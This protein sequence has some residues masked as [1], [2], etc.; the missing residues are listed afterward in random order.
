MKR[1]T[2]A[3][4]L[5][6]GAA[7][8]LTACGD[9]SPSEGA[10][11]EILEDATGEDADIDLSDGEIRVQT[12]EGEVKIDIDEDDG[13]FEMSV[14]GSQV[15]D[16]EFDEDGEGSMEISGEEGEGSIDVSTGSGEL[17]DEW[18]SEIPQP[19]GITIEG[20]STF[21][22]GDEFVTSVQGTASPEWIESY[23][24]SVESAGF[25]QSSRMETQESLNLFYEG[26][27]WAI[28]VFGADGGDGT[29][30]VVVSATVLPE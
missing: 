23:G 21:S 29:W 3:A 11:E 30:D 15:V 14:D 18:P 16:A 9:S 7:L 28:T 24:A 26:N 22:S 13:S 8:V 6:A 2:T 20:S 4:T 27:G 5:L 1:T 10:I 17:P 25:S 19:D 12:E